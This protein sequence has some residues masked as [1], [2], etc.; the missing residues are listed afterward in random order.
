MQ[1]IDLQDLP[2]VLQ[3]QYPEIIGAIRNDSLETILGDHPETED[4][5]Q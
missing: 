4:R 5:D 2:I 1:G 3:I